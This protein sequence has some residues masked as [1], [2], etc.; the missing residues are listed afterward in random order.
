MFR[1]LQVMSA[2]IVAVGA[3]ALLYA[4]VGLKLINMGTGN[5]EFTGPFS[6]L[7]TDVETVV[8]LVLAAFLL[9][10]VVWFVA[11]T[12]QRERSVRRPPR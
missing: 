3:V 9:G 8:P 2:V 7:M 5:G 11:S 10:I 4:E 6:G 12:V 1:R